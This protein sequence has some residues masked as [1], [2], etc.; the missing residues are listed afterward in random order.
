[1]PPLLEEFVHEE[2]EVDHPMRYLPIR[3]VYS[4]TS[5]CVNSGRSCNVVSKKVK[6]GRLI[7]DEGESE[8]KDG[9]KL[10]NLCN[11]GIFRGS[12]SSP[13]L[14][15]SRRSKKPRVMTGGDKSGSLVDPSMKSENGSEVDFEGQECEG[16]GGRDDDMEG[17]NG[18]RSVSA[19]ASL[20]DESGKGINGE[21]REKFELLSLVAAGH[22]RDGDEAGETQGRANRRSV[23]VNSSV[24]RKR[25]LRSQ[26]NSSCPRNEKKW[27]ELD[28]EE[29]DPEAF[30]GLACKVF[31]PMDDDWFKGFVVSYDSGTHQHHIKYNDGDDEH[32]IIADEKI[33]FR[34]SYE[35]IHCLNL[36]LGIS[37]SKKG[38]DHYEMLSLAVVSEDRDVL[39]PGDVVWAKLTGHAKWPALVVNEPD[40]GASGLKPIRREQS[41]FVQFFGTHDFAR[42]GVKQVMPFGKGVHSS[43]DLKCKQDSFLRSLDEVKL[44]LSN[45]HF[46][47]RMLRYQKAMGISHGR[48]AFGDDREGNYAFDEHSGDEMMPQTEECMYIPIEVGNLR[49]T[50]LGRVVQDSVYFQNKHHVWPEGYTAYRKFA[51]TKV[52]NLK[53]VY[54][55]EVLR[56][57]KLMS[58]PLFRVTTGEGEQIDGPNP[59]AC[60]KEVYERIRNTV[61]NGFLAEVEGYDFQKSGSYMF[62]FSNPI[63]SKHIQAKLGST[64]GNCV[65][66]GYRAVRIEWKDLDRCNVCHMD[67]EYEGNL[68]LQCDK[69]RMMVHARCYGELEPLDGELW[70]CK[71]CRDGAPRHPPP[72]CLC[73]VT[74]G[75]MKPTSDGQWAHLACA[76][77]IPETC[78]SDVKKM[79]PI[80]GINQIHKDRWKLLCSICRVTYGACIQCSNSNCRVAYHPL[81]ARAAGYC[82]EL[83]DEDR[84]HL[85]SLDEDD[86]QCVRLIS[87][88]K[89]HSQ[90]SNE[91][92]PTDETLTLPS[93]Q[94]SC[95]VPPLNLSGCAR[96]EPYLYFRRGQKAPVVVTAASAKR[97]YVENQ[98]YL[99]TGYRQNGTGAALSLN[100]SQQTIFSSGD[101]KLKNQP[102]TSVRVSSMSEKYGNMK[103]TFRMRLAFGK[104]RI[105]GFGVFAKLPHKAGDMVIEYAGELVR[106]SIADIREHCIYNSLVGAGTYMFRIDD[107][108]VIDAT[109]AGSVAHLINHSCEPNCYSR[110]ISVNGD[111]HIIIFA[112]RDVNHWEELTYDYRFFSKDVLACNCGFPRC[113]GI[114]NDTE[115]RIVTAVVPRKELINW[116]GE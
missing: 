99:V 4:S 18:N 97:L 41:I 15:Y 88:C 84:I 1:M 87:F 111:E 2:E 40:A 116:D 112:K 57:P 105:H 114:V 67:E 89:R 61:S 104:S 72:C 109:K 10:I 86:D 75:A 16:N 42:I 70:H 21:R 76:M 58:R 48:A 49:V 82:V 73:P 79:E 52:P 74:G 27:V 108:R 7:V 96:T 110:V 103:A 83:E 62:G 32:L 24:G 50:N 56:N 19:E 46:P 26:K 13:L 55:M 107:E 17:S 14:V 31:W 80:D 51:S 23:R 43:L 98:P 85:M 44:Y 113:R 5:P 95:Y 106:P 81:C 101:Q 100:K 36:K 66:A 102:E 12:A 54:K 39:E 30:V 38:L 37:N 91:R 64:N 68:F 93:R 77:W 71:L 3:H 22:A 47:E 92:S 53:S 60:W 45:Q 69:C 115:E 29:A 78:L 25:S 94:N 35:E 65:P 59:T 28:C 11:G 63:V 20:D 33:K 6:A 8:G 34:V 9:K 90:P